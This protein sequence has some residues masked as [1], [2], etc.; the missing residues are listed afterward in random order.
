VT[1]APQTSEKSRPV[2]L[3]DLSPAERALER[4]R[5]VNEMRIKNVGGRDNAA[6]PIE[7]AGNAEQAA[8]FLDL[9]YQTTP[10]DRLG[11]VLQGNMRA[12][13]VLV[14][15]FSQ[16][17]AL[18]VRG[19]RETTVVSI[20]EDRATGEFRCRFGHSAKGT[21]IEKSHGGNINIRVVN[22]N[23]DLITNES[24]YRLYRLTGN[25]AFTEILGATAELK[26][27]GAV[28][29][30]LQKVDSK[31]YY[32]ALGLNPYAL[33]FMSEEVLEVL[34]KGMKRE[35]V[36]KLHPDV[37]KPRKS[38]LEYLKRMLAACKVLGDKARRDQYSSWLRM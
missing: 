2:E 37:A 7:L 27:K 11:V 14:K 33:R 34:I 1:E 15:E 20:T 22:S 35:L 32:A 17:G 3:F 29:T 18:T 28:S 9:V 38:E 23:L 6:W 12:D 8:A 24:L 36:K 13:P 30:Q 10:P 31:G 5:L 19:G 21:S 16:K 4:V 25:P 26:G